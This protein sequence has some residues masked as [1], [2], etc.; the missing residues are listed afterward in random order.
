MGF[1]CLV[2]LVGECFCFLLFH[3]VFESFKQ[4]IKRTE[5]FSFIWGVKIIT[6]YVNPVAQNNQYG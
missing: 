1:C 2:L 4:K 5:D 6:I 3:C